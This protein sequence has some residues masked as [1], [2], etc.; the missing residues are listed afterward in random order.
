M[1]GDRIT[2]RVEVLEILRDRNRIK[3]R[4]VCVNHRG[5]EVLSGE[6]WMLPPPQPV[7]YAEARMALRLLS[8]GMIQ[9]LAF[10]A[11]SLLL[12]STFIPAEK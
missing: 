4:T 9:P 2:A 11:R 12:L 1:L 5:E 8:T 10:T 6:A 3:L 7:H